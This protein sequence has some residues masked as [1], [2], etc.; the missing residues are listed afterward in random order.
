MLKWLRKYVA[1]F[2]RGVFYGLAG[3]G[4][5]GLFVIVA[6]SCASGPC[7]QACHDNN[8]QAARDAAEIVQHRV[9]RMDYPAADDCAFSP[10]RC[11]R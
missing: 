8:A 10:R 4:L 3:A 7:D 2:S 6:T 1:P 5:L 9:D 11:R